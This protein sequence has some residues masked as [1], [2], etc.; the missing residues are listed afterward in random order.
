M[1]PNLGTLQHHLWL[2]ELVPGTERC[3]MLT[4]DIDHRLKN[5]S[6]SVSITRSKLESSITHREN[7]RKPHQ[8]RA[9]PSGVHIA[10]DGSA[11]CHERQ[12][13]VVRQV[14]SHHFLSSGILPMKGPNGIQ[15]LQWQ[16]WVLFGACSLRSYGTC[17]TCIAEELAIKC[18]CVGITSPNSSA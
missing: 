9:R 13:E 10:G 7:M 14:A 2:L 11:S 15:I 8:E 5:S 6:V 18:L 3:V 12:S 16:L 17:P 1:C 4:F